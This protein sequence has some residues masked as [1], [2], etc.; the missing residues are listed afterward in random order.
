MV[1][2]AMPIALFDAGRYVRM[3]S[4]ERGI[5]TPPVNPCKT[6]NRIIRLRECVCPQQTEKIMNNVE[7][8][9]RYLFR[10]NTAESQEVKE[11]TTISATRYDVGTQEISSELAESVPAMS[12]SEEFVT[13]MSSTAI[14][15]PSS[16][17]VTHIHV[18][19][20]T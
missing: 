20:G 14:K 2:I 17:P 8:T 18:L 13:I 5:S 19:S 12:R 15:Q 7:F 3:T 16:T 10:E 6:R 11:I 1:N 4:K 9:R